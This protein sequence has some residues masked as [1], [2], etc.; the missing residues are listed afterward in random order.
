MIN[1]YLPSSIPYETLLYCHSHV[2]IVTF[3]FVLLISLAKLYISD[4]STNQTIL[5]LIINSHTNPTLNTNKLGMVL[6]YYKTPLTQP[7]LVSISGD[8]LKAFHHH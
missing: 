6:P 7:I 1:I 3:T 4:I 8:Y 2:K 5:P